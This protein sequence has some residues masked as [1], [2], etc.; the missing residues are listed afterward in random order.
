MSQWLYERNKKRACLETRVFSEKKFSRTFLVC[1][2]KMTEFSILINPKINP[3][4]HIINNNNSYNMQMQLSEKCIQ[5]WF[6][7]I[8]KLNSLIIIFLCSYHYIDLLICR[9]TNN[10][11]QSYKLYKF[12]EKT[13]TP[14]SFK[15]ENRQR[16]ISFLLIILIC[17][18]S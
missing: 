6:L 4:P 7:T 9:C 5:T 10:M 15:Y 1:A 17:Y 2:L 16:C 11:N 18:T 3:H 8:M 12:K 14:T 13:F